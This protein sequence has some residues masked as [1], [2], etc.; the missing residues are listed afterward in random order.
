MMPLQ[1]T[2]VPGMHE[3]PVLQP[4]N[5]KFGTFV[6][7]AMRRYGEVESYFRPWRGGRLGYFTTTPLHPP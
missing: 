3:L 1:E 2:T 6:L 7:Q 5:T 4:V